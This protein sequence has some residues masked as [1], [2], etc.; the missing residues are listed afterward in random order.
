MS[1]KV[2][3]IARTIETIAPS[4]VLKACKH[5]WPRDMSL[6]N[7]HTMRKEHFTICLSEVNF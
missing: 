2:T 1:V 3:F 7:V 5:L 4:I 6:L